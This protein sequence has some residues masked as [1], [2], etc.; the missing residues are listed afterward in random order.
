MQREIQLMMTSVAVVSFVA[1]VTLAEPREAARPAAGQ[2]K[3]GTTPQDPRI[4]SDQP[5]KVD[6]NDL[7]RHPE[8]Y[9]GKTVTVEGEAADVLGAHLFTVDQPKWFH[10]WGGMLVVVPEPFAAIVRRDAPVRVTGT[11]EKVVLAEAKRKWSFISDPKI[12]VDLFEKPVLVAKEV[13]TVTPTVVSLK[14]VPDQPLGTSGSN[15]TPIKDL[16]QLASATDSSLVGSRVDLTGTVARTEGDGFWVRTP[17]G[18][19]VFVLPATKTAVRAGQAAAI[20]GTVLEAPQQ[21]KDTTDRGKNHPVYIYA[22]R[23]EPK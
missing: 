4:A 8:K 21:N 18:G 22:D 16:N 13:T 1:A 17:S 23:M 5:A 12:Q 2:Q 10:L 3:S 6:L 20:H 7:E 11:V 9:I 15:A 19:E 14:I